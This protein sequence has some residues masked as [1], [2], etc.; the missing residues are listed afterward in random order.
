MT[1]SGTWEVGSESRTGGGLSAPASHVSQPASIYIH[2]PFCERKCH[3]CDFNSGAHPKVQ[4]ERYVEAL[5]REIAATPFSGRKVCT[6]FFGG[7]TPSVLPGAWLARI[8]DALR[9]RFRF[10]DDVE[11][12]VEC[13]PGTLASERL[14]GETTADF[15]HALRQAGVNRLSF[16]VQS[17]D[18]GLLKR[19]GR[20]HS[21]EQAEASVRMARDAGFESIN[22]DLMFALPGQT[23]DLWESTL[24]RALA[25]DVPHISAYSLIVEPETPFA[26]WDAQGRLPRPGE[27]QEAAMYRRVMDRLEAAGL[28]Q[29]EVSAFARPGFRCRHNQVYWRNEEYIGFGN[30]ATSYMDGE[31]FS[32]EPNLE[33]YMTQ[34]H[35]GEDTI[36]DRER[37][38][39]DGQ[40]AETMMMGL[41]MVA[42]VDRAAFQRRFGQD[43]LDRYGETIARFERLSLLRV[44][45]R[46]I[47]LTRDGF[48]L[49][50]EVWEAFI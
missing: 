40:M 50:N 36:A 12:T 26:L 20:I 49:A 25:L 15:L 22:V 43:P 27:D 11:I 4:R 19:L 30:G 29:Y 10:S 34:A 23:M 37:L 38:D 21:P 8:L 13:N 33:R 2:I 35:S 32:R 47:A 9:A 45:P 5:V 24:E 39:A 14:A 44:T 16:G 17:F 46:S 18:A 31:R 42:G 48:F 41:R 1:R 6:V 3:Y 7:G 28:E